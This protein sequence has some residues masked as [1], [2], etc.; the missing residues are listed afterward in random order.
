MA[1]CRLCSQEKK[2]VKSH[3]VPEAF[4]RKVRSGEDVPYLLSKQVGYYPKRAPIGVYDGKILC[5]ECEGRFQEV[6]DYGVRVLLHDFSALFMPAVQDGVLLGFESTSVDQRKLLRF[7]VSVAWR[8]SVSDQAFYRKFD[9]GAL[10]PYAAKSVLEPNLDVD[11]E[12]FSCLLTIRRTEDWSAEIADTMISP[13]PKQLHGAM[14]YELPF[15]RAVAL[16]R[17]GQPGF[18]PVMEEASLTRNARLQVAATDFKN[19]KDIRTM[20]DV[21]KGSRPIPRPAS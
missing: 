6:D 21:V 11:R 9:L 12:H 5:A 16:L 18:P 2:L 17:I 10:L 1:F 20:I 4:W 13:I 14:C 8:A 19:S 7:F 15:G 3:I